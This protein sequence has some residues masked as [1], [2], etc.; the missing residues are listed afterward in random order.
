MWNGFCVPTRLAKPLTLSD[1]K[2]SNPQAKKPTGRLSV[3]QD[4]RCELHHNSTSVC[5]AG[6][7]RWVQFPTCYSNVTLLWTL[8][9]HSLVAE[10]LHVP[11]SP[12]LEP[13]LSF[14]SHIHPFSSRAP[15]VQE[16][17]PWQTESIAVGRCFKQTTKP[18]GAT[19]WFSN[20]WTAEWYPLLSGFHP[21]GKF[22]LRFVKPMLRPCTCLCQHA[23]Y[24]AEKLYYRSLP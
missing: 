7:K 4:L 10:I 11:G 23:S 6:L 5:Q 9:Y 2:A 1:S 13:S 3:W 17:R 24:A 8:Q 16:K 22:L 20:T 15:K 14:P 12:G 18:F 19:S 21:L